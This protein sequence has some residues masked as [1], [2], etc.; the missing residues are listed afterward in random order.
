MDI[1]SLEKKIAHNYKKIESNTEKIHQNTGAL[2]IL[3]GF[4]AVSN[5]FFIMWVI[6]F[7]A[8]LV[9]VGYIIFLKEDTNTIITDSSQEVEQENE[10]GS[11]YFI[12]GDGEING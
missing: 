12:G 8:L 7:V 10:S 2:E 6:T 11:N 4:K 3:K 1:K 5:R 9:A